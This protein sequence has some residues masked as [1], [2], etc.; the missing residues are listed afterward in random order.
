MAGNSN[1][2][3]AFGRGFHRKTSHQGFPHPFQPHSH[4]L[5]DSDIHACGERETCSN[6]LVLD[7]NKIRAGSRQVVCVTETSNSQSVGVE[8][9][10]VA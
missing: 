4:E 10:Q 7:K 9:H 3:A 2:L 8:L 6:L 5:M 1:K